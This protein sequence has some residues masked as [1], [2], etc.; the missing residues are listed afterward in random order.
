MMRT[1]LA[2]GQPLFSEAISC[3]PDGL[4]VLAV[5]TELLSEIGDMNVDCAISHDD[6]VTAHFVDKLISAKHPARRLHQAQ[7]DLELCKRQTDEPSV[8]GQFMAPRVYGQFVDT[9][10]LLFAVV[11]A[12]CSPQLSAHA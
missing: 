2:T 4:N 9:Q 6:I 1:V 10:A 11:V 5:F 12:S 7:E 3:A 8:G